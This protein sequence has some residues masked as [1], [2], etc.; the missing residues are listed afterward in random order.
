M[1]FVHTHIVRGDFAN[2]KLTG[3]LETCI[4][5]SEPDTIVVH[6]PLVIKLVLKEELHITLPLDDIFVPC[7]IAS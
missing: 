4:P 5:A 7:G 6:F 3:K 2:G 1:G